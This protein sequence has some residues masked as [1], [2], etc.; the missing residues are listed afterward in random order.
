MTPSTLFYTGSTTKAFTA[1][2][3]SFLVD[4][5]EKYPQLQWD[6]PI[7]QLIRDDFVLENDYATNHTTIE[8]ALSHRSGLPGH[9]R[10]LGGPG[11]TV[12]SVVQ[13]L[14]HIPMTA[15]PRTKVPVL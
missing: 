14:R 8:D 12:Q 3:V 4:D 7:N 15:E 6:T 5:N 11:A 10:A 1:A 2:I 9:D 13:S